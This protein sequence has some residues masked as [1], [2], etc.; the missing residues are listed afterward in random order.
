VFEHEPP[1]GSPLL[2]APNIVLAPHAGAYTDEAMIAA[3]LLAAQLVVR[4]M[5]GEP[6]PE[7]CVVA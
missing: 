2:S 6:L 7:E 4:K 1:T 5:R 3:N